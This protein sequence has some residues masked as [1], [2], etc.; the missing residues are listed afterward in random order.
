MSTWILIYIVFYVLWSIYGVWDDYRSNRSRFVISADCSVSCCAI[1]GMWLFYRAVDVG[2]YAMIW[3]FF[4]GVV[5]LWEIWMGWT[6][7]TFV[8]RHP[9]PELTASENTAGNV[10]GLVLCVGLMIPCGYMLY[11][12]AFS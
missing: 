1:I 7:Y 10:F 6:D 12:L 11:R 3:K 8:T 2:A 9:D 5:I 4:F